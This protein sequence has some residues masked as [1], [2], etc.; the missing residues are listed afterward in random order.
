M[1]GRD[2]KLKL[3]DLEDVLALLRAEISSAGGQTE[4]ARGKDSVE[5]RSRMSWV[6]IGSVPATLKA[7]GLRKV[8]VYTRL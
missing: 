4:W 7:L 8:V 6:D 1:A 5:F 3:L 2:P